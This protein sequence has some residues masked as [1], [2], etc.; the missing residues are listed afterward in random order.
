[1]SK[2]KRAGYVNGF[3][4][5]VRK[6]KQQEEDKESMVEEM[7]NNFLEL[8]KSEKQQISYNF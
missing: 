6:G 8:N 5:L 4:W 7:D 2:V 1:M 3:C